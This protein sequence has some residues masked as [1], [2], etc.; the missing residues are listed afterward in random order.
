MAGR[1]FDA[2]IDWAYRRGVSYEHQ[3]AAFL[4]LAFIVI[5]VLGWVVPML[6][7]GLI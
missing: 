3:M 5:F 6:A 7:L 2:L 1:H 4:V